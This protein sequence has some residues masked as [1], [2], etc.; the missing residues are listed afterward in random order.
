M[1]HGFFGFP[2]L[3]EDARDAQRR[4]AEVIAST[5]SGRKKSGEGG[6]GAG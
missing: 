1:F 2:E 6:G 4:V 5:V 3:L